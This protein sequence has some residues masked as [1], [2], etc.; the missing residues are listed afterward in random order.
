MFG[1]PIG[2]N[3]GVAFP[4]A[5]AYVNVEAANLMRFKA[6]AL[7]DAHKPCGA[8]AN[9]AKLLAAD[10]SWE[11]ANA[12]LQFHG[13]FGFAAEYDVERKF[14]ETRLYQV[15]PISTNLILVVRRRTCA[16]TAAEFL[17]HRRQRHCITCCP[18]P[19]PSLSPSS[20][21]WLR[22]LRRGSLRTSARAI[23]KIE[24]PE[25]GDFARGYDATVNGMASHFVWL[26]R[27]KESLTL[28]LKQPEATTSCA[29][30]SAAPTCSS[31]TSRQEP[32]HGSGL[33]RQTCGATIRGLSPARSRATARP[34]RIATRRRTTCSCRARRACCRS[35]AARRSPRRSASRSPTFRRGCMR[36]PACLPPC[37]ERETTGEGA[38]LEVSLFDSLAEWMSYPAVLRVRRRAAAA[39]RRAHAAIAPYG[40]FPAGDGKIVYLGLQNEREWARFCGQVLDRPDLATDERFSSNSRRT[41]RRQELR[42]IV[43]GAFHAI[44]RRAGR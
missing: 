14:R 33:A 43:V 41:A 26:N 36:S 11:A 28:D 34:A 27:C 16:W 7:F 4:I 35:P 32:W 2:Q 12:C 38:S 40:P 10:A 19:T 24:R 22:R 13:G 23:I 18:F 8:E 15:A 31:T 39:Q 5:R 21:P 17:D 37:Y 1:R 30:C 3:Q 44:H 9:M 6:C 25:V 29:G 20:R 42:E